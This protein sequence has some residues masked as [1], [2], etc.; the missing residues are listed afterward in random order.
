MIRLSGCIPALLLALNLSFAQ[1]VRI[2]EVAD[3]WAENSVNTVIFRKNPLV[4]FG[5]FQFI[6][7]YDAGGKVILGKRKHAEDQWELKDTGFSG[8]ARDA[9]CSISIMA[10]GHGY[11][12]LSW[13]HHGH[14][15]RYARSKA[16]L[17]LEFSPEIPMTGLNEKNVTYPEFF[18][19]ANGALLFMYRDGASGRGNLVINTYDPAIQT[20]QQLHSNLIDGERQRNAYWQSFTDSRGV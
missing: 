10:D 7:F 1:K 19:M 5:E 9:H 4:S 2:S 16:P 15:L 17:S 12:H 11:L 13:G 3:G 6:S 8:D 18:K 20:W 14:P